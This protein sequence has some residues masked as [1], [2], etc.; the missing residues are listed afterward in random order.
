AARARKTPSAPR[1][2]NARTAAARR[3]ASSTASTNTPTG[4]CCSPTSS[5]ASATWGAPTRAPP[6]AVD[7]GSGGVGS[8]KGRLAH[9]QRD[10]DGREEAL[11]DRLVAWYG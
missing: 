1:S 7:P 5:S 6:S 10:D 4:W 3:I 9:Q 8:R 11:S 2:S